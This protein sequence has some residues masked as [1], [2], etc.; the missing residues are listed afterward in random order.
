MLRQNAYRKSIAT[1]TSDGGIS[2]FHI[3]CQKPSFK[4]KMFFHHSEVPGN[5]SRLADTWI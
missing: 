3:E 4:R 2:T 1:I 5:S